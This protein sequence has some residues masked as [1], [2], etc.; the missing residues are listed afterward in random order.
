MDRKLATTQ[1]PIP[2][3]DWNENIKWVSAC[4]TAL[5][6]Y[7]Y[8]INLY[9]KNRAKEKQEFIQDI[10]KTTLR[11]TLD[12][13][14]Q[15]IKDNIALLFEYREDDRKHIDDKFSKMMAELRK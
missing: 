9:F 5:L 1:I 2:S 4:I 3:F 6:G 15:G 10:V 12:H 14:L 8:Y 13:E 7:V 11:N